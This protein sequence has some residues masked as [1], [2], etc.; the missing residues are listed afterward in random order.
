VWRRFGYASLYE[1]A[2]SGELAAG[3]APEDI[4]L[5]TEFR[6]TNFEAVLSS[7]ATA[8]RVARV[9]GQPVD[10]IRER[11]ESVQW[12][13]AAAVRDRHVPWLA[14]P[15]ATL[16]M[17]RE[18]LR[19]YGTVYSTNYDL[20]GY[21]S[22]MAA[23]GGEGFKDLFWGGEFDAEDTEIR[24][25]STRVLYLHGALHLERLDGGRTRKRVAGEY[26]DLLTKFGMPSRDGAIPLVVTEGTW[27]QKLEAIARSDY[28]TFAYT[29]F[30]RRQQSLV[31]FGHSLGESDSHLVEAI[32]GWGPATIAVS[33][34]PGAPA[35]E[36]IAAKAVLQKQLP[37]AD[38]LFFDSTTHPLGAVT[39]EVRDL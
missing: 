9:L 15:S 39:L 37:D 12:A 27:R 6:T 25:K 17:I 21:W 18:E 23:P 26:L 2:A 31:V 28:L 32:K 30:R 36:V 1:R 24:D 19:R 29:E 5:F 13:L 11:Y 3:L 35:A 16:E 10:R 33:M 20:L 4:A 7:L 34:R 38:L 14:V 8:E 22:I